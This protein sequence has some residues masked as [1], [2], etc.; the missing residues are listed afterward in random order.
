MMGACYM[1]PFF[2][3]G[4]NGEFIT[5]E[6]AWH[7]DGSAELTLTADYEAN[8]WIKNRA[9]F[10]SVAGTFFELTEK[11][12]SLRLNQSEIQRSYTEANHLDPRS[13][14]AHTA[15]ELAQ[16]YRLGA[17]HYT[18]SQPP[19]A[20]TLK[21]PPTC[22]Q[23]FV[24]WVKDETNPHDQIRWNIMIGGDES[25]LITRS[26]YHTTPVSSLKLY[27]ILF[28]LGL[29]GVLGYSLKKMRGQCT[30]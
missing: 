24:L 20:L 18:W 1:L 12:Q 8:L 5:A 26:G 30:Q 3:F 13:P 27:W 22:N 21:V 9:D 7:Q 17:V 15:E 4:H 29:L 11:H 16:I 25:P 28:F 6:W 10:E 23:T 14:L 19:E 2:C